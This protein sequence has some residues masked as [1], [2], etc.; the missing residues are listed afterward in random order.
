MKTSD[1]GQF[2]IFGSRE[3]EIVTVTGQSPRRRG[4]KELAQSAREIY[5]EYHGISLSC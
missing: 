5:E 4:L 3:S 1:I 2:D